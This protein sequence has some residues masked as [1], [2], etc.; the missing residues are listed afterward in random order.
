MSMR[1]LYDKPVTLPSVFLR[2]THIHDVRALAGI[3]RKFCPAR[4]SLA[5][6]LTRELDVNLPVIPPRMD[7]SPRPACHYHPQ[8][9]GHRH[10]PPRTCPIDIQARSRP[11][12]EVSRASHQR[13]DHVTDMTI[14]VIE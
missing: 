13:P 1:R 11:G 9:G 8:E 6:K 7:R 2:G 14:R 10:H 4:V 12:E 3:F 5:S